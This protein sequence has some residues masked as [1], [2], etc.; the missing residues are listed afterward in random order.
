M[1]VN[2]LSKTVTRQRRGCDLNPGPY[3]PEFSKLT[4]GYRATCRGTLSTRHFL[5]AVYAFSA[6]TLLV[7]H[8]EEH[9]ACKN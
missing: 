8:Q 6:S 5:V 3:A 4:L 9:P 2:S 7:G 1:G